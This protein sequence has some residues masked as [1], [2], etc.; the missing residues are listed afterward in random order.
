M[1]KLINSKHIKIFFLCIITVLMILLIDNESNLNNTYP[2]VIKGNIDLEDWNFEEQGIVKLDGEWEIYENKFL[3][4]DDLAYY[5]NNQIKYNIIPGN[6][7]NNTSIYTDGYAT[8]RVTINNLDD[9]KIYG[10]KLNRIYLAYKMWINGKLITQSGKISDKKGL[11]IDKIS[12]QIVSVDSKNGKCEIVLWGSSYDYYRGGISESIEIG[13][14]EQIMNKRNI[15]MM[16]D[17]FVAGIIL[18]MSLYHLVLYYFRRKEIGTL[19][20]GI[21]GILVFLETLFEGEMLFSYLFPHIDF[22]T[23]ELIQNIAIFFMG[24]VFI[25]YLYYFFEKRISIKILKFSWVSSFIFSIFLIIAPLRC[26]IIIWHMYKPVIIFIIGYALFFLIKEVKLRHRFAKITLI[27]SLFL[28]FTSVYDML[29]DLSVISSPYILSFGWIAFLF[30]HIVMISIKYN[31]LLNKVEA[32]VQEL[33]MSNEELKLAYIEM[34]EH[35]IKRTKE[36]KE[37][38]ERYRQLVDA[39]FEG[40]M[41]INNGKILEINNEICNMSNYKKEELIGKCLFDFIPNEYHKTIEESIKS[42]KKQYYEAAFIK[43]DGSHLN[44]EVLS[45]PFFFK[46]KRVRVGAIRDLTERKKAEMKLLISEKSLKRAQKIARIGS[47]EWNFITDE[48]D[49]SDEMYRIF[50]INKKLKQ[51]NFKMFIKNCAHP[52]YRHVLEESTDR[53]IESGK[54]ETIEYKIVRASGE[55]RWVRGEA[56]LVYDEEGKPF[57]LAGTVQDITDQKLAKKALQENLKFLQL[58]IDTIPNPIFYKDINGIYRG[59]NNAYAEILGIKKDQINGLTV[60]DIAPKDLADIYY[61]A[62]NDLFKNKGKQVYEAKLQ[63]TKGVR[64]DVIFTKATYENEDDEIE[65]LVGVVVDIT[66]LKKVQQELR[67]SSITDHLTK[68]YNRIKFNE[69]LNDEISR[70]KRYNNNLS[71][72]MFDIDHFK[73]VNDIY[74]H[75]IGDEILISISNLVRNMSRDTD[76]VARWGGEE[77]MILLKDTDIKGAKFFAERIRNN[78]EKYNFAK[79]GNIT[80]SFGVTKF[81]EEDTMETFIIRV[82][83]ALYKAKNAGRNRVEVII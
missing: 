68:L 67:L 72:I 21:F 75:P 26:F 57:K 15:A 79:V 48:S 82:D 64:R 55:E 42:N 59:C 6:W 18:I 74:G 9:N 38:E 36:L 10:F 31:N 32:L 80:C 33:N 40:I 44:I 58:L 61:K 54:E 45:R 71:I 70:V 17:A 4:S 13:T 53:I 51:I 47:W 77:F 20:F 81:L 22:W 66:Q 16:R 2:E 41:I 14:Q 35:V 5:N 62:D 83:D 52:E 29:V 78:I 37:S 56:S 1:D 69:V 27:G 34:E 63:D 19:Y 23:E 46:G 39:P 50:G 73:K 76:I 7:L 24:A 25:T 3:S 30:S 11:T 60:Y 28:T 12:P 65:G 8:Y 49:I 43:K